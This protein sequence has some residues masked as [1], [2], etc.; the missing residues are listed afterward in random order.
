MNSSQLSRTQTAALVIG[1]VGAIAAAAYLTLKKKPEEAAELTDAHF[2]AE[3]LVSYA[4]EADLRAKQISQ[5]KYNLLVSLGT[6][7]EEGFS[8]CLETTFSLSN[9]DSPVYFDFQGLS[10]ASVEI[11]GEAATQKVIFEKHRI[12]LP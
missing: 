2:K 4:S 6:K 11:N 10:I 7:L 5:V 12:I 9:L 1:G 3:N 8:G